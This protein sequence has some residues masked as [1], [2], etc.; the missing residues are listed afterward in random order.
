MEE[1]RR[2]ADQRADNHTACLRGKMKI[3]QMEL[4]LWPNGISGALSLRHQDTG[5]IP[6]RSQLQL[7]CSDGIPSPGNSMC[8][9]VAENRKK[10]ERSQRGDGSQKIYG[11]CVS[12]AVLFPFTSLTSSRTMTFRHGRGRGRPG[13]WTRRPVS[14]DRNSSGRRGFLSAWGEGGQGGRRDGRMQRFSK[15]TTEAVPPSPRQVSLCPLPLASGWAWEGFNRQ[16]REQRHKRVAK[17]PTFH[18]PE[19]TPLCQPPPLRPGTSS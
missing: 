5:S 6:A 19:T 14:R 10:K 9:G 2:A 8:H 16:K 17:G 11:A 4:P 12:I 13:G 18:T 1:Q 15:M 3:R 7:G